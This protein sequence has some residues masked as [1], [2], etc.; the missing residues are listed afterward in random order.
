MKR[1]KIFPIPISELEAL[2]TRQLLA[3]LNRLR[4]CEESFSL[5]DRTANEIS[6]SI[7]FKDSPEWTAEYNNLKEVLA[8]REHIPKGKELVKMRREKARKGK[9]LDRRFGKRKFVRTS[10]KE[11]RSHEA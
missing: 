9:S 6:D 10:S 5:S 4:Q 7:E 3:R 8:H 11:S 1:K 2:T